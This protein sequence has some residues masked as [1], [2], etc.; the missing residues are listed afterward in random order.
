MTSP[1]TPRR[2]DDPRMQ[3]VEMAALSIADAS[4]VLGPEQARSPLPRWQVAL[5]VTGGGAV[6]SL[7]RFVLD[8]LMPSTATPTLFELPWSTLVANVVGAL[9]L[10]LLAGGLEVRR[11]APDWLRPALGIGVLGGFTTFST[12]VLE[13]SAMVGAGFPRLAFLY[14]ST[15]ML[16]ALVGILLGLMIGRVAARARGWARMGPHMRPS[17]SRPARVPRPTVARPRRRTGGRTSPSSGEDETPVDD[18]SKDVR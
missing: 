11:D 17:S 8:L 9:G 7:L 15:T 2:R 18:S 13:G 4:A 14:A 16:A 5:L 6:G 1:P 3:T 12:V 10:G